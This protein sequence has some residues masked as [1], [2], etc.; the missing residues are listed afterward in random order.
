MGPTL[1]ELI[2]RGE[3]LKDNGRF[4]ELYGR[5][6][7]WQWHEM[8]IEY[9]ECVPLSFREEVR[10]PDDVEKGIKWLKETF[11]SHDDDNHK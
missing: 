1:D 9:L 11:R 7:F 5:E 2:E 6:A 8:C 4:H 3:Q 10:C